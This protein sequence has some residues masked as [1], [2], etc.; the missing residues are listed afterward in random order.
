MRIAVISFFFF[1]S[2]GQ[3]ISQINYEYI[4]VGEIA[5]KIEGIDQFNTVIDSEQILKESKILLVFYR[6]NWCP[7]CKKYLARLQENLE[8][9]SE[10][11]VSV[12]VVTPERDEKIQET[13]V[14]T[15]AAFSIIHDTANKIMHDFKVA[16][17]VNEENVPRYLSATQKKI[18]EYNEI[19]NNVLPVPA[20]YLIDKDNKVIYVHYDPNYKSRASFD[21]IFDVL[22]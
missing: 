15:K 4:N 20:T 14:Y 13:T 10:Q 12:I 17:E 18:Q 16:F 22:K 9:L 7:Y 5:P 6:G 8:K 3:A 11:G 2:I 1:I 21:E 19:E